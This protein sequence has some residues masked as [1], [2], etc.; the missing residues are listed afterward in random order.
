MLAEC[1]ILQ[2]GA[3]IF[4]GELVPSVRAHIPVVEGR[5]KGM[6]I[7]AVRHTLHTA[8]TLARCEIPVPSPMLRE[9]N[10]PGRFKP[11]AHQRETAGFLSLHPRAFCLN[12]MGCVDSATEYLSPF[13]WRRMDEYDGG[14]VAQYWPLTGAIEL[15][16]P[17]AYVKL[18]CPQMIR[19]KNARGVDQLLSP[20]H[21]VLAEFP[22]G[23]RLR[24]VS[25]AEVLVAHRENAQGFRG[26]IPNT[27]TV[28]G[29][30]MDLSAAQ[31]RLHVAVS[32]DG[33]IQRES[34]RRC[35]VRLRKERKI[36]RLRQLL[37]DAGVPY[38]ERECAPAGFRMFTFTALAPKGLAALWECSQEQLAVVADELGRWDGG[39]RKAGSTEFYS[40]RREDADFAQYAFCATGR[41]ATVSEQHREDGSVDYIVHARAH[42][43]AI[44]L[45]GTLVDG[46]KS[47]TVWVEPST[48]GFKYCFTVP[49]TFLVFRRNGCVFLSGNTGKSASIL[50]AWDYL[51][52]QGLAGSMLVLCP[53]STMRSVWEQE[54]FNVVPHRSTAVLYGSKDKRLSL[55]KRGADVY[56]MNHDGVK[57]IEPA[58]LEAKDIS[59]VVV[60][61]GTAFSNAQTQGYKALRRVVAERD[62]WWSTGTPTP[63]SPTQAWAQCRIVNPDRVPKAFTVFR[64]LV[65]YR[66]GMHG[67]KPKDNAKKVVHRAMQPAICYAKRDCL[68][69]PPVTK[70]WRDAA[71]TAAQTKMATAL[72]KEWLLED[73]ASGTKIT[74]TNAAVRMAKLLQVYTGAVRTDDGEVVEVDCSP[75]FEVLDELIEQTSEK[76]LVFAAFRAVLQRLEQHLSKKYS[77]GVIDGSVP[78]SE[79]Q[80]IVRGF[81]TATHPRIIVAHPKTTSHGLTLTAA[82]LTVWF[83]PVFSAEQYIQANNRTDRPGQ[84]N[85]VT[86]AHI[87]AS[88]LERELFKV[89]QGRVTTQNDVLRLYQHFATKGE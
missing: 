12:D 77:V 8:R 78:E 37:A 33:Y 34:S 26:K 88:P 22:Y 2:D 59:L 40:R 85:P 20:E 53:L 81:Q 4:P 74:A 87:A 3:C 13:G 31:L 32:A 44:G 7:G 45:A 76:V 82:N 56:I 10:W 43:R 6:H 62:L 57:V 67:W 71:L 63:Q 48:D 19:F 36:L 35:V 83:G 16:Q 54:C 64:D 39:S 27:F 61:E 72:Q 70:T 38:D 25:A 46:S 23:E 80:K 89:L 17:D 52:Q 79:R 84:R 24:V 47:E 28:V 73:E 21:R 18:P 1:V 69:L 5:W 11:Y 50:W 15:V 65:C 51:R 30:G 60:D 58:L 41:T 66:V 42:G 86:I 75:R 55:L 49:S 14:E 9:Y 68:D 29:R